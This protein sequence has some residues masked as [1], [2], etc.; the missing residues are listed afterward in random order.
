MTREQ[1]TENGIQSSLP[2][3]F[4]L[5]MPLDTSGYFYSYKHYNYLFSFFEKVGFFFSLMRFLEFTESLVSQ[6]IFLTTS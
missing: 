6:T 2:V 5:M 1:Y 4:F 3:L